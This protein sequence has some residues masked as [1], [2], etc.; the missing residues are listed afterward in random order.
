MVNL[1]DRAIRGREQGTW[2]GF[3]WIGECEASLRSLCVG[4]VAVVLTAGCGGVAGDLGPDGSAPDGPGEASTDHAVDACVPGA[5][6]TPANTCNLG[7]FDCDRRRCVDT[8]NADTRRDGQSCGA[9]RVCGDGACVA[10]VSGTACTPAN[11]CHAGRS[12]CSSG[13]SSCF[14]T[15]KNIT[16][17]TACSAGEVCCAGGCV[18]RLRDG[19]NCGRCG[20][21]CQG[22]S[23]D[24]GACQPLVLA[25]GQDGARDIAVDSKNVY[26]SNGLFVAAVPLGGG[27][28]T[29]LVPSNSMT[30]VF[31]ASMAIDATSLYWMQGGTAHNT[32]T[33][34]KMPIGGGGALTLASRLPAPSSL[35]VDSSNVYWTDDGTSKKLGYVAKVPIAGGGV[36]TL[37]S[38]QSMAQSIAIDGVN[39]YWS[40]GAPGEMPNLLQ[41][42]L[43]GGT[44]TT[45]AAAAPTCI[46]AAGGTVYFANGG[47]GNGAVLSVP[48]GGGS[49]TTLASSGRTGGAGYNTCLA[50]DPSNAY[51]TG[52]LT[53]PDTSGYVEVVPRAGGTPTTL[54]STLNSPSA[55]A[56]DDTSVYWVNVDSVMKVAKP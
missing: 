13:A 48:I 43:A 19:S 26:W 23:C 12:S 50:L 10:C 56:V 1:S 54:A 6:C 14:D 32:G 17:G 34:L 8:G 20:H 15:G 41:S 2:Y 52:Y 27:S 35:A 53:V 22:G 37:Q 25:S 9:G 3:C 30:F 24:V 5:A 7:G 29:T 44:I 47:Y 40:T 4:F 28:I 18:D 33:V 55:I 51:I 39:M 42:P 16:D 49:V 11:A 38:G 21:S 45:L 46:V 36:T 31:I